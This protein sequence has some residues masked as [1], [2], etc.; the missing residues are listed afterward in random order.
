MHQFAFD[1]VRSVLANEEMSPAGKDV[2]EIGSYIV[3]GTIRPLFDGSVYWGIDL[4]PGPGV[5]EVADGATFGED[6][7]YDIVVCCEAL[8]HYP[9]VKRVVSNVARILKPGGYFI[10][11]V[12]SEKRTPHGN[13]GNEVGDGEFYSGVDREYFAELLDQHFTQAVT[14]ENERAGDVYACAQKASK[15]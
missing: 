13:D 3:N 6:A 5:D 2:L 10:A 8:E 9:D 12:A 14:V 7:S 1:Y 4:R 11:T 15:K